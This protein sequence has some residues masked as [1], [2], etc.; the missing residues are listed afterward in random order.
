MGINYSIDQSQKTK[1]K[2]TF[3]PE[4][5]IGIVV[6]E[7]NSV[8]TENLLEAAI[9]NLEGFGISRKQITIKHVPGSFELPIAAKWL[10]QECNV[11]GVVCLGCLIQGET[12]HFDFISHACSI[13]IM[14]VGLETDIPVTFGVITAD[15]Q[16]Q[17]IERSGGKHGNKGEEAAE[18][19]LKMIWLRNNL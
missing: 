9:N 7:W 17:A 18:S 16:Q 15:N 4:T 14:N 19:L 5:T 3:P 11:E 13:G 12:R 1:K 10:I 6:S 8:I 2:M